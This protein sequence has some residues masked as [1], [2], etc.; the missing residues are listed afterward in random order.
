VSSS[1]GLAE[2][3]AERVGGRGGQLE[4]LEQLEQLARRISVLKIQA[5]LSD[6]CSVEMVVV[7]G[8]TLWGGRMEKG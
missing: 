3:L 4:Q 6:Q 1:C 5:Y 7:G 8:V 2:R